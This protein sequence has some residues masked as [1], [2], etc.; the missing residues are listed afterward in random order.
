M[1]NVRSIYEMSHAKKYDVEE[2]VAVLLK[3]GM[4][5]FGKINKTNIFIM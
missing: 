4:I 1:A 2:N 5:I 3:A